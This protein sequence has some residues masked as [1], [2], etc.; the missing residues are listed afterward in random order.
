MTRTTEQSWEM[1]EV[2]TVVT[3]RSLIEP[4][5]HLRDRAERGRALALAGISLTLL[6]HGILSLAVDTGSWG[7][8]LPVTLLAAA[9]FAV[10]RTTHTRIAGVLCILAC[11]TTPLVGLASPASNTAA[12]EEIVWLVAAVGL[13]GVFMPV[14]WTAGLAA[15]ITVA[16]VI[17]VLAN[18]AVPAIAAGQLGAMTALIAVLGTVFAGIRDRNQRAMERAQAFSEQIVE[19]MGDAVFVTGVDGI[20]QRVN[21]GATAMLGCLPSDLVGQ[22]MTD[23]L[24]LAKAERDEAWRRLQSGDTD[25]RSLELAA[26]GGTPVPVSFRSS[27]MRDQDGQRLA[28]VC[29]ARDLRETLRLLTDAAEAQ[30]QRARADE[31]E[32]VNTRLITT[33]QQLIQAAKL[34]TVGELAASVAHELNN[35]L[36]TI[37]GYTSLMEQQLGIHAEIS[38]PLRYIPRMATAARRCQ[39]IVRRWLD[40]SRRSGAERRSID[41]AE[42]VDTTVGLAG[43]QLRKLGARIE[44]ELET[45][46]EVLGDANQ[47]G[48]VLMNLLVNASQTMDSPGTVHI[49]GVRDEG[50]IRLSVRDPGCG[51]DA[52]V[53]ERIFEPFYTTKPEGIGTGLGLAITAGIVTDHDGHIEVQSAPGNGST[54]TLVLPGLEIP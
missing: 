47:L 5:E 7:I 12:V 32:A 15:S 51:M 24:A 48:Q 16:S 35:P 54:F 3:W 8:H 53:R 38:G 33:Q 19:S 4:S 28:N 50:E 14:R 17:A 11:A 36:L 39:A 13:P 23:L 6:A 20:V 18:P 22:R 41:L 49:E 42:V 2:L 34:A 9:A 44:V 43:P 40:F 26:P 1:S 45:E 29:V 31:L 37:L 10:S 30:V 25:S 52:E 27:P 21:H 46:L